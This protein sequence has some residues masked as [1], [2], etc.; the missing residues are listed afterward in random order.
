MVAGRVLCPVDTNIVTH[1]QFQIAGR[2]DSP[3]TRPSF[4]LCSQ[5]TLPKPEISIDMSGDRKRGAV[6]DASVNGKITAFRFVQSLLRCFGQNFPCGLNRVLNRRRR[7]V[8]LVSR[9]MPKISSC[10]YGGLLIA[11]SKVFNGGVRVG[12]QCFKNSRG[13]R[14]VGHSVS[15]NT[16]RKYC[17]ST[18][19]KN[20]ILMQS[21]MRM[22]LVVKAI[23][24]GRV[25]LAPSG[26]GAEA[27]LTSPSTSPQAWIRRRLS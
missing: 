4:Q 10:C 17:F 18:L 11:A 3:P 15:P 14:R 20:S 1:W 22:R 19:H 27:D 26:S 13:Y 21:K 8:G 9:L 7:L 6:S 12:V 16:C 5:I 23:C 25:H 24:L 2:I